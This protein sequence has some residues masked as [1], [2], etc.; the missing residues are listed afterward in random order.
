MDI[1]E[2]NN[3]SRREKTVGSHESGGTWTARPS[4]CCENR[5]ILSILIKSV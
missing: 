3:N 2:I 4:P 5:H 1:V